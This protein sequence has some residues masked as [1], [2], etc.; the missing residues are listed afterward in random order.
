MGRSRTHRVQHDGPAQPVGGMARQKHGGDGA[1]VQ[2][3]DVQ[4]QPGTQRGDVLY[5]GGIVRHDGGRAAGQHHVGAVVDGDIVGDVMDEGASGPDVGED[6]LEHGSCYSFRS[7]Q[8]GLHGAE[9]AC[10]GKCGQQHACD[11]RAACG[12]DEEG[13][14]VGVEGDV[15]G[16]LAH[17]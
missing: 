2:S 8:A 1:A 5:L 13:H 15:T 17:Q 9:G 4:V 12:R 14:D 10:T 6:A 7:A 16:A 3:A 11:D